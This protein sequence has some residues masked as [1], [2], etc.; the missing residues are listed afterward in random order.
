MLR[1]KRKNKNRVER[2]NS[3]PC[4]FMLLGGI[5]YDPQDVKMVPATFLLTAT[6]F[7]L[8]HHFCTI[9]Q[10]KTSALCIVC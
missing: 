3:I 8:G 9:V 5:L 4:S 1:F 7:T 2:R 10:S 6:T